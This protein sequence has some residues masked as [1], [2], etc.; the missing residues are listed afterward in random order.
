MQIGETLYVTAPADFR[1]WLRQNHDA[2]TEIW[3]VQY[4]KAAGKSSIDY[5]KAVEEAICFGWIDSSVRSIDA[6]RYATRFT[7]RKPNSHWTEANRAIAVRMNSE[8]R[9]TEAGRKTLPVDLSSGPGHER[10]RSA[11]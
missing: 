10:Q 11:G 1:E 6:E 4:K 5:L 9:M 8:G 7:P 3:L 2:K